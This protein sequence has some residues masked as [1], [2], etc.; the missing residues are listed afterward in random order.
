MRLKYFHGIRTPRKATDPPHSNSVP[1][2]KKN[3]VFCLYHAN[4]QMK[5][6]EFSLMDE[7]AALSSHMTTLQWSQDQRGS[8]WQQSPILRTPMPALACNGCEIGN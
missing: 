1:E 7:A 5:S 6:K 4:N 3:S 8:V 2:E